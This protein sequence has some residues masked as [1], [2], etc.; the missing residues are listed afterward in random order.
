MIPYFQQDGTTPY[1]GMSSLFDEITGCFECGRPAEHQ[2]HVVPK[3]KGGKRTVPLCS[4]CHAKIHSRHLLTTSRLTQEA[5]NA[6]RKRGERIG[7]IPFGYKLGSDGKTLIQNRERTALIDWMKTQRAR[8]VTLQAICD[9]LERNGVRTA[10]GH[11]RWATL[12]I[13]KWTDGAPW[14]DARRTGGKPQ[15]EP[16]SAEL[17]AVCR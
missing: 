9:E 16:I 2:H 1:H 17:L 4:G 7:A 10:K 6:K 15:V 12:V 5:L 14:R 3:S 13:K 8:G 11:H